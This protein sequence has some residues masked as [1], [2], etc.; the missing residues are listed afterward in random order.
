[1]EI[2]CADRNDLTKIAFVHPGIDRV[3]RDSARTVGEND[4]WNATL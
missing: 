4:V 3:L 1:M 2:G